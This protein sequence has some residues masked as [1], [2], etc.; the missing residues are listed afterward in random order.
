MVSLGLDTFVD[1][2]IS[3]FRLQRPDFA[4]LGRRLAEFDLPTVLVMEGGYATAELGH[5]VVEV[6]NALDEA[7]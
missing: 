3:H 7:R 5:N 4:T 6:L 1:D 2:P